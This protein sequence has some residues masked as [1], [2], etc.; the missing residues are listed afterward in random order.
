VG[1][2]D[3]SGTDTGTTADPAM[4]F[5]SKIQPL[6]TRCTGCHPSTS[7]PNLSSYTALEAKYKMRPGASNIL[8]IKGVPSGHNGDWF[9]ATQQDTIAKWIDSINP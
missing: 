3:A 8:V 6:V 2:S 9:T 5:V 4:D 7:P 1:G